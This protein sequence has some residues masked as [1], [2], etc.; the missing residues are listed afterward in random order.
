MNYNKQFICTNCGSE[1]VALDEKSLKSYE[2]IKEKGILTYTIKTEGCSITLFDK[3]QIDYLLHSK[4]KELIKKGEMI[5]RPETMLSLSICEE[6]VDDGSE[7]VE[8]KTV[9]GER[10]KIFTRKINYRYI[11]NDYILKSR[12]FIPRI[13]SGQVLP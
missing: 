10:N 12:H 9:R 3:G 5:E 7:I 4:E 11:K 2:L 6:K 8:S 13:M 1:I